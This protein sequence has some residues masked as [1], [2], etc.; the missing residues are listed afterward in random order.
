MRMPWFL[1]PGLHEEHLLGLF[2]KKEVR[3]SGSASSWR[4]GSYFPSECELRQREVLPKVMGGIVL[5]G[6]EL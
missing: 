2:L 3:P 4:Q 6:I 1:L 5:P